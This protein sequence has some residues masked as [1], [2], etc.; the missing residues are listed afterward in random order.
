MAITVVYSEIL[1]CIRVVSSFSFFFFF[2]S[3][4]RR[5]TRSLRDWSSDVCSSDL[6][7][8]ARPGGS[9]TEGYRGQFGRMGFDDVLTQLEERRDH[10]ASMDELIDALPDD[11]MRR[12]GYFGRPE[13][14]AADFA[15][16]AGG[17]DAAVVRMITT[18][19]GP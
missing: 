18:A 1:M 2:F 12:V 15:R 19:P 17:L 5:H 4:R 10:G 9:R 16:L 14:V 13:G 8:L 6:F 11:L 3:S 7:G